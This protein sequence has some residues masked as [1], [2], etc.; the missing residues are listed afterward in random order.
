VNR[1][2]FLTFAVM[3][4][5][6]AGDDTDDALRAFLERANEWIALVNQR[7][8]DPKSN[9]TLSMVERNA[10]LR[11]RKAWHRA[12]KSLNRWYQA[13]KGDE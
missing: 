6:F 4:G 11:M 1:R 10:Y 9:Q 13:P 2:V 5:L 7:A 3:P 12:E 8:T